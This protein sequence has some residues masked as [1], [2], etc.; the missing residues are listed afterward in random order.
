MHGLD[1][2]RCIGD[3]TSSGTDLYNKTMSVNLSGTFETMLHRPGFAVEMILRKSDWEK[4]K[5]Y[6]G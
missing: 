6:L 4:E 2:K 5:A 1:D 3:A